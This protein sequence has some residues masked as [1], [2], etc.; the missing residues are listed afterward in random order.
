MLC[1]IVTFTWPIIMCYLYKVI[2]ILSVNKTKCVERYQ[3]K[4]NVVH[5]VYTCQIKGHKTIFHY[6]FHWKPCFFKWVFQDHI[7]SDMNENLPLN[8]ELNGDHYLIWGKNSFILCRNM[9]SETQ[10]KFFKTPFLYISFT[11]IDP[12]NLVHW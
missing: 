7:C 2:P 12:N 8:E 9:L 1:L 6:I 10:S 3:R 11:R 5:G 4:T